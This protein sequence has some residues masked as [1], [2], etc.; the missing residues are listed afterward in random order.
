[1][2][3]KLRSVL[4]G[5]TLTLSQW[6]ALT[7]AAAVGA[8]VVALRVQGSRLHRTQV[9]LLESQLGNQAQTD[10]ER[11]DQSRERFSQALRDYTGAGGKL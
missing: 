6:L 7:A 2:I 1:M 8:L 4:S 3:D 11:V 5:L 9:K 10:Q